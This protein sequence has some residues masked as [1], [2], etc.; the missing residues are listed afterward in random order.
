M[1]NRIA[2]LKQKIDLYENTLTDAKLDVMVAT[3][4][5]NEK[6]AEIATQRVKS[7][8]KALRVLNQVLTEWTDEHE[9]QKPDDGPTDV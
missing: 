2:V 5:D 9:S 6:M 7:T 1:A 4:T 3:A 8:L